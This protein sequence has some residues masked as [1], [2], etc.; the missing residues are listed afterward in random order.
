[1]K[2]Y[3]SFVLVSLVLLVHTSNSF[4]YLSLDTQTNYRKQIIS[5][6]TKFE[7]NISTLSQD[8]QIERLDKILAKIDSYKDKNISDKNRFILDYV[9]ILIEKKLSIKTIKDIFWINITPESNYIII[10]WK[11]KYKKYVWYLTWYLNGWYVPNDTI[12][13]ADSASFQVHNY[14]PSN[15]WR[16]KNYIYINGDILSGA[17]PYTFWH[18]WTMWLEWE[19]IDYFSDKNKVYCSINWNLEAVSWLDWI[20][21]KITWTYVA[22]DKDDKYLFDSDC[23][24]QIL[25]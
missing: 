17:D 20:S 3:I 15:I 24:Y 18:I 25:K 1:M 21:F 6:F 9:K 5:A 13:W 14:R 19:F 4:A 11:V 7:K 12:T 23:N 16:D 8:K 22:M 10:D 2:K